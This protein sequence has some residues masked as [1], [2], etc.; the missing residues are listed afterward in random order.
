MTVKDKKEIISKIL[1][2]LFGKEDNISFYFMKKVKNS[3][4]NEAVIP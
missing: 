1:E 4:K 3:S 2:S